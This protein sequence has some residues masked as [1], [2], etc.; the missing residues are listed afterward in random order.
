[1]GKIR[2]NV[3]IFLPIFLRVWGRADG[4]YKGPSQAKNPV[5]DCLFRDG[6]AFSSFDIFGEEAIRAQAHISIYL[7]V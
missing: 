2:L 7:Y 6:G 5:V 3:P 1:M 4:A